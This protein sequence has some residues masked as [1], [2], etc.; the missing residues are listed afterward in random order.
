MEQQ[1]RSVVGLL[2]VVCA[3]VGRTR[4]SLLRRS[5]VEFVA[6]KTATWLDGRSSQAVISSSAACSACSRIAMPT[7]PAETLVHQRV[8]V[9]RD[10]G[11][12]CGKGLAHTATVASG[13]QRRPW[14][15]SAADVFVSMPSFSLA[16][17]AAR[18]LVFERFRI[19]ESVRMAHW[20]LVVEERRVLDLILAALLAAILAHIEV[21][22]VV[23]QPAA[24]QDH[25]IDPL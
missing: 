23:P 2:T 21:P 3:R 10:S 15:A 13:I 16:G 12:R 22:R 11:R 24:R 19:T 6:S 20:V 5:S 25:H 4:T 14:R 1:E 18:C 7:W 17:V 9:F 8:A